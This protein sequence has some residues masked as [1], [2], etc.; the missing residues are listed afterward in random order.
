M[1]MCWGSNEWGQSGGSLGGAARTQPTSLL[2]NPLI[3][4]LD[5]GLGH[6]CIILNGSTSCWGLNGNGQL[7]DNT[8]VN[9][10]F[11][12]TPVSSPETFR[13]VSAGPTHTCAI[14]TDNRG[15]CWGRNSAGQIGDN[16]TI[17]RLTPVQVDVS[18]VTTW[19]SID[20]GGTTGT[21]CGIATTNELY[22]WGRNLAGNVGDGTNTDRLKPEPVDVGGPWA[23]VSAS[24]GG[25]S[26]ATHATG[27]GYCWGSN[28]FGQVGNDPPVNTN[29]PAQVAAFTL[30]GGKFPG[31]FFGTL[32]QQFTTIPLHTVRVSPTY[33]LPALTDAQGFYRL[34]PMIPGPTTLRL[35]F[36]PLG[37]T[38]PGV[39]FPVLSGQDVPVSISVPCFDIGSVTIHPSTATVQVGTILTFVDTVRANTGQVIPV[40]PT[41][42]ATS[43]LSV[44]GSRQVTALG[45]GSG[46]VTAT[47][48]P[49]FDQSQI[50][51]QGGCAVA[52]AVGCVLTA[53]AP[54]LEPYMRSVGSPVP[55]TIEFI[56]Q[57]GAAIDVWW[58]NFNGVREPF[59]TALAHGAPPVTLNTFTTHTWVVTDALTG[60]ALGVYLNPTTVLA[61]VIQGSG[62]PA[63]FAQV[64][65]TAFPMSS[66]WG[67]A[68]T[69]VWAFG[70]GA[71]PYRHQGGGWTV[72]PPTPAPGRP[73]NDVW[74]S[75]SNNVFA[76]G[77]DGRI[78]HWN[79]AWTPQA[80]NTTN[81]LEAVG[82][83]GSK[84]FAVGTGGVI[85]KTDDGGANWAPMASS[86]IVQLNDVWVADANNAWAVGDGG[87]VLR[88]DGVG[89][90]PTPVHPLETRSFRGVWGTSA[91][92]VWAVGQGGMIYHLDASGNWTQQ[93]SNTSQTLQAVSGTSTT[94]VVVVGTQ[95]TYLRLTSGGWTHQPVPTSET[96]QDIWF[97]SPTDAV[98]V[99]SNATTIPQT[100]TILRGTP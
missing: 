29:A 49:A 39:N 46:V 33:G 60:T 16:T 100:G 24:G 67:A 19:S 61:K 9:R 64:Q 96:I 56:N 43:P 74:G 97:A 30:A 50:T 48:S 38:D 68:G 22:C 1:L 5:A 80:S 54:A 47:A 88:Y 92:D 86:T 70:F 75:A 42:S 37:C 12:L 13:S 71:D 91:T 81:R 59:L 40:Q 14:T 72:V 4:G 78:I 41:Y 94:Q 87:V 17:E 26:C 20:A 8:T 27:G 7:G 44:T 90:A 84:L 11:H 21:T 58:L 93:L 23:Q 95:G 77:W 35:D 51:V 69:D 63:S 66:I 65:A 32:R 52:P 79:G 53:H 73:M 98:I 15:F 6:T 55:T 18:L 36:L 28:A 2:V 82:G 45:A 89:W 83:V 85:V 99:T 57:S 3:T 34:A 25:H 76:V 31:T 10:P 62:G